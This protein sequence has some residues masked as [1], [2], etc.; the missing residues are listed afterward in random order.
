MTGNSGNWS[1]YGALWMGGLESYMTESFIV[2]AFQ[3]LGEKP[4]NIKVMRNRYTGEPAGYCFVHFQTDEEAINAM[5][6]LNG[7][8]IP[9]TS[10]AI[11]F[12]LNNANSTERAINADREFSLWIGDLSPDV[13]DYALYKAFASQYA[14]VR[15]AKV[16]LDSTGFSKGYGFIR[17]ANEEDQKHCLTHMSGYKGLGSKPLK[18]SGAVPKGYKGSSR[19][20]STKLA[21]LWLVKS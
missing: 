2:T 5:H 16:V 15:T 10:P 4:L 1:G 8:Q 14:S 17:F 6:K 21:L 19:G 13:D 7:K 18:I 20:I 9:N 3:R 12:R 11:R